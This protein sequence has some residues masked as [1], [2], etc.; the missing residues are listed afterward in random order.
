MPD[1][2]IIARKLAEII[3][4]LR[5][6]EKL[7]K[8]SEKEL[9]GQAEKYYFAERVLERLI[10]TAIDLNMHICS[11]TKPKMPSTY[12]DSFIMLGKLEILPDN[13]A[14]KI[15]GSTTLRNLLAHE[16]TN[17]DPKKFYDSLK[18]GFMDYKNYAEHL[19]KYLDKL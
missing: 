13:L 6:L 9:F 19:E 17:I 7:T 15:A 8:L 18:K 12:Y 3:Q 14:K 11:E 10:N 1:K 2:K 5:H 16:Y 4:E